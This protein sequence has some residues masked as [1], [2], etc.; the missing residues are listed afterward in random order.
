MEYQEVPQKSQKEA[1]KENKIRPQ[2]N[3]QDRV[4][5]NSRRQGPDGC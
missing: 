4:A 1:F 2:K 5:G 3:T